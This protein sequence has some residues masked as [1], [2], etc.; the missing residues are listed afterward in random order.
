MNEGGKTTYLCFLCGTDLEHGAG[1]CTVNFHSYRELVLNEKKNGYIG[2][3]QRGAAH[4]SCVEQFLEKSTAQPDACVVCDKKIRSL[5]GLRCSKLA[6]YV[7]RKRGCSGVL[8]MHDK[9][10]RRIKV[11]E[12]L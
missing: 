7:Y 5:K 12:F 9:C 6:V 4:F 10:L 2:W 1:F 11:K 3:H 8:G